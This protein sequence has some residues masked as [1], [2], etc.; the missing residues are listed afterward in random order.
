MIVD[1]EVIPQPLG[2]PDDRY[3]HVEAA[4]AVAAQSGLHY[5]VNALGT[6]IEGPATALWSVVRR[7]HEATLGSG[8]ASV[9]TVVKLAAHADDDDQ[10]TIDSLTRKF[11]S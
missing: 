2:P 7:M 9:V 10:P 8:A 6:T 3:R 11:R 4:I 5:E 1:I